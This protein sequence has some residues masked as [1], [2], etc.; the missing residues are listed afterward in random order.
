M[1]KFET[2]KT[3]KDGLDIWPDLLRYA[4][5][6]TPI[7]QIPA[8]DLDRLKWYGV[9]HRRQTPGF[10]MLR[11]RTPGGRLTSE[12]LRTLSGIAAA[13][14]RGAVDLTTRQNVQFRWLTL[15]DIPE[16][17]R[18]LGDVGISTRQSGMDNVR[19]FI[20]CPLAG[21]DAGEVYDTTPL[22]DALQEALLAAE[23]SF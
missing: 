8:D 22:L 15:P 14:G 1:N 19:N 11:L 4:A 21:I 10:F 5:E 12:Q 2:M 9:F 20:G 16:I 18:R 7:E 6:R 13:Y 17:L 23:K 3:A